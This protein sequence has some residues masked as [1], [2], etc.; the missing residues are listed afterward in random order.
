LL[1][2]LI[3]RSGLFGALLALF[4]SA[5]KKFWIVIE[6]PAAEEDPNHACRL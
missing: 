3:I 1:G 2:F 5:E 6:L 4:A